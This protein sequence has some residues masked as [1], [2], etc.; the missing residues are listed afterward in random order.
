MKKTR[1]IYTVTRADC[2]ACKGS[3]LSGFS[4]CQAMMSE[5]PYQQCPKEATRSVIEKTSNGETKLVF[6]G[7]HYNSFVHH[8]SQYEVEQ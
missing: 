2:P 8:Y 6:C 3:G 5:K 1:Y 7:Y 4:R